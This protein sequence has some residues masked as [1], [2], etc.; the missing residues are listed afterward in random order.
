MDYGIL[1]LVPTLSCWVWSE[2]AAVEMSDKQNGWSGTKMSRSA[3]TPRLLGGSW[4]PNKGGASW[5]GV[6]EPPSQLLVVGTTTSALTVHEPAAKHVDACIPHTNTQTPTPSALVP[7][8]LAPSALLPFG[9]PALRPSCVQNRTLI[10]ALWD[11]HSETRT[12]RL[13]LRSNWSPCAFTGMYLQPQWALCAFTGPIRDTPTTPL[14]S[15]CVHRDAPSHKPPIKMPSNHVTQSCHTSHSISICH[16]HLS[17]TC[18]KS[19]IPW[20][21]PF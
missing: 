5:A 6:Q 20:C 21:N 9:P 10:L 11:S 2:S 12:P 15:L 17:L 8:A 14:V 1:W 13:A 18:S 3:R 16:G 7:S 4:T 19:L